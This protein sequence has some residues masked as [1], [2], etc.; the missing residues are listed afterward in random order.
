MKTKRDLLIETNR[1][2]QETTQELFMAKQELERKNKELEKAL[3]R[4][5]RQKKQKEELQR[6]LA[7]LKRLATRIEAVAPVR[8]KK[9]TKAI[10][11]DLSLTYIQL[12]RAYIDT[13]DLDKHE[14]LVE[15]FCRRLIEYNIAPKGVIDLHLKAMPQVGTIGGLETQRITFEARMVLLA[16]MTK[17][18]ELLREKASRK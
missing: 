4:E 2:L 13:K 3:R 5:Q 14:T 15:E 16:V 8:G 9:L 1:R 17:Y 11:E 18:A 10:A 6:E 7:D 12:I